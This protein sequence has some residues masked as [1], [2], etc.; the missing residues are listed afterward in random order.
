MNLFCRY[1]TKLCW[2][3]TPTGERKSLR[4]TFTLKCGIRTTDPSSIFPLA[5]E[6]REK[7]LVPV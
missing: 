3:P 7:R 2:R 6:S 4:P 5:K 1:K